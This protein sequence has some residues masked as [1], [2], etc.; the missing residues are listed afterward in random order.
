MMIAFYFEDFL[1]RNAAARLS[2]KEISL[3]LLWYMLGHQHWRNSDAIRAAVEQSITNAQGE[4]LT[5]CQAFV[6]AKVSFHSWK[7]GFGNACSKLEDPQ[8]ERKALGFLMNHPGSVEEDVRGKYVEW[9]LNWDTNE[10][11]RRDFQP[12]VPRIPTNK[13]FQAMTNIC[14]LSKFSQEVSALPQE[15]LDKIEKCFSLRR[16]GLTEDE[17]ADRLGMH[18]THYQ[19]WTESRSI[20]I[21]FRQSD[22]ICAGRHRAEASLLPPSKKDQNT[23]PY[24]ENVLFDDKPR[25]VTIDGSPH[26]LSPEQYSVYK[27]LVGAFPRSLTWREIQS[28]AGVSHHQQMAHTFARRKAL[29]E[30]IIEKIKEIGAKARWKA[31]LTET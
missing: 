12:R 9:Y 13:L 27:C 22:S 21:R 8:R 24:R 31:K 11:Y 15:E 17:I 3:D 25:V 29:R 4:V 23:L 2:L 28:A 5:L 20:N 14:K 26:E 18:R 1:H 16:Q 10:A 19:S 6:S 7:G 30:S